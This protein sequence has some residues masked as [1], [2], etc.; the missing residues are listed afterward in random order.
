MLFASDPPSYESPRGMCQ[1]LADRVG[2]NGARLGGLGS[3]TCSG[4]TQGPGKLG[5][6]PAKRSPRGPACCLAVVECLQ[7]AAP[8]R[9]EDLT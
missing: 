3:D 8:E 2:K 1:A 7:Q 9:P 6:G 4:R 5:K